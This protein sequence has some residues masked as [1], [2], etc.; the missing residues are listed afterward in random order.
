MLD[1]LQNGGP[2][3]LIYGF[4]FVWCGASFQ[5]LVMAEMASMYVETRPDVH[6]LCLHLVPLQVITLKKHNMTI[7]DS[8]SQ[9]TVYSLSLR[10]YNLSIFYDSSTDSLTGFHWQVAPSTGC[11]CCLLRRVGT[12]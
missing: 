1:G 11:R 10:A 4:L 12:F 6:G 9:S 8:Q 2:A 7:L 3:G 5:T